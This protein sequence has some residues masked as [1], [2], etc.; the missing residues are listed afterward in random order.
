[1]HTDFFSKLDI[2]FLADK[3]KCSNVYDKDEKNYFRKVFSIISSVS[4]LLVNT[5]KAL[6]LNQTRS[7]NYSS[8]RVCTAF[9]PLLRVRRGEKLN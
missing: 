4:P 5:S 6:N 8:P 9:C 2:F 3:K 7:M 1:M